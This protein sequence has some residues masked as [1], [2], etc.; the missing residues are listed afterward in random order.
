MVGFQGFWNSLLGYGNGYYFKR[1]K[2]SETPFQN[3]AR[4]DLRF[5]EKQKKINLK[6]HHMLYHGLQYYK[7]STIDISIVPHF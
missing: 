7:G 5:E 6:R 1:K 2:V 4:R 3:S